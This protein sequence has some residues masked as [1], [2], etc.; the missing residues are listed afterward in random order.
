MDFV[1]KDGRLL[2]LYHSHITL[3]IESYNSFR[4]SKFRF[5]Q[6]PLNYW[7]D[8]GNHKE[9]FDYIALKMMILRY[10][11][12][13]YL[14]PVEMNVGNSIFYNVYGGSL[15]KA[16]NEIYNIYRWAPWR[17]NRST[18]FVLNNEDQLQMLLD[19]IS[20]DLQLTREEDWYR[21]SW[22]VISLFEGGTQSIKNYG[23]LYKIL[24]EY[25]PDV[26]WKEEYLL[27]SA[28]TEKGLIFN[29]VKKASQ[30]WLYGLVKQIYM[31]MEVV[32]EYQ[33]PELCF[34][35]GGR[36]TLDVYVPHIKVGFE[37]QG[38]QHYHDSKFYGASEV[39]K[40]RDL[41]KKNVCQQN[42]ITLI[43]VPYWWKKTPQSLHLLQQALLNLSPP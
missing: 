38:H 27:G 33:H 15:P 13:Y 5:L 35:E 43:H 1:E 14:D 28:G 2:Y 3:L 4:W 26:Q 41:K 39:R 24:K 23:G 22:D 11:D 16:L 19:K 12:W 37:Y 9:V 31:D 21:V 30:R 32:E 7:D 10:E 6:V 34:P 25:Y 36:I 17:F 29:A 18:K 8:K 40:A 20:F 42:G